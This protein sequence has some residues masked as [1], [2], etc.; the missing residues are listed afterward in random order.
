M[1][2][3]IAG[4]PD[5]GDLTVALAPGEA[6]W[7]EGGAMSRMTANMQVQVRLVG[8]IIQ[9]LLRRVFGGESLLISEYTADGNGFVSLSPTYPGTV[10]H[11]RLNGEPFILTAGAF[12]ACTPGIQLRTRFGGLKAF[13]S[14]EGAFFI[15]CSGHG[16]LFYCGYGGVLEKEVNGS[17]IVDT[18]H[19]VAWEKSLDYQIRGM[20]GL[21]QTL[22]SG[23]GLVMQF[24]GTGKIYLQTR[25]L[26]GLVRWLT[27][28]CR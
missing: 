7:A 17:L 18:G 5:Y 9:A 13:F 27:S 2:F 1:Q 6:I 15:E 22:F 12:L 20:G 4:N 24:H 16:D 21:K 23:E 26:G 28:Y 8:G 14:G 11:R 10:L 19:V 3:E 25:H